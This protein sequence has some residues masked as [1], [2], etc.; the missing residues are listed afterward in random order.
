MTRRGVRKL[1]LLV[2]A[3][4]MT[5]PVLADST[6][7]AAPRYFGWTMSPSASQVPARFASVISRSA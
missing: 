2:L 1:F 4:T 6:L 5:G 7:P 3:L